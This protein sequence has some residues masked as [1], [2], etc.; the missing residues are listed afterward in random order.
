MQ[1]IPK[2]QISLPNTKETPQTEPKKE[3][4]KP[5]PVEPVQDKQSGWF[6]GIFNKLSLK[7][8]NQMKLPDDKNPTVSESSKKKS[9]FYQKKIGRSCGTLKRNDG[10]TQMKITETGRMISNRPQK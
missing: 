9:F 8:K 10:L 3:V 7:P 5:K 6:G 2:P 4:V 1:E